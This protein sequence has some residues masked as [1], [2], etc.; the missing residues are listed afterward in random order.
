ME[1]LMVSKAFE[2]IKKES[3]TGEI[4]LVAGD[5]TRI[6][7]IAF[8]IVEDKISS[9]LPNLY[10]QDKKNF[11]ILLNNYVKCALK[12]YNLEENYYNIKFILS[13]LFV[14]ITNMEMNNIED[15]IYKYINF[16]NDTVLK[17]KNGEK[18]TTLGNLNYEITSQSLQQETPFCFKSYF[19]KRRIKIFIT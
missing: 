1:K 13:Y 15:Y 2:E 19:E 14:N 11:Y 3:R 12:F 17:S 4:K 9:N 8:N 7:R 10:I 18:I 6:L 16:I 5:E